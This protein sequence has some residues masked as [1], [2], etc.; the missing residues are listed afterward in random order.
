MTLVQVM[1]PQ[2]IKNNCGKFEDSSIEAEGKVQTR[3][4]ITNIQTDWHMANK[5][6]PMSPPCVA[7]DTTNFLISG[8][9]ILVLYIGPNI[10]DRI[11]WIVNVI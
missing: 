8:M 11:L 6:I 4:V 3:F 5:V 1:T 2:V 9:N 10:S 7:N